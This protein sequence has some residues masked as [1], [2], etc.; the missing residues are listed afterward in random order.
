MPRL[1]HKKLRLPNAS[2]DKGFVHKGNRDKFGEICANCKNKLW[3]KKRKNKII[4]KCDNF[5]DKH[6]SR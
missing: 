3:C 4:L 1:N 2:D 5:I 6:F